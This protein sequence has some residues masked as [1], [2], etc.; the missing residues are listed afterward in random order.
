MSQQNRTKFKVGDRVKVKRGD[1][2][3]SRQLEGQICT[4]SQVS[5]NAT[6]Y[7]LNE[8]EAR[9]GIWHEELEPVEDIRTTVEEV[10]KL[11]EQITQTGTVSIPLPSVYDQ[12][13]SR[14][15][16]LPT[17][18]KERKNYP[19]MSGCLNYFP[20]ALAGI[21]H[22]SKVGNDKHNPG[23]SLYHD[24]K[25]SVDHGDCILRHLIDS[26]DL[27]SAYKRGHQSVT[28]DMILTE[29]RQLTW[30]ALA[31]SQQIHE[32]F[33]APLAPAAKE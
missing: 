22:I 25:K 10:L 13:I 1:S 11:A 26:E 6:Y 17:D 14:N 24:R 15:L 32:Q 16:T 30:R 28:K 29:V 9:G 4:I 20:A 27:L 23:E 7:L 18:S 8:D 12:D 2:M 31:Y 33:G 21:A 5:K 3:A 19:L